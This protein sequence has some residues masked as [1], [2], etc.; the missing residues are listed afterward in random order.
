MGSDGGVFSFGDAAFRGSMATMALNAP[1]TAMAAYGD[2]YIAVA[3]DG[4]VFNFSDRPFAGSLGGGPPIAPV[5]SV[6]TVDR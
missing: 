4:G 6:A 1:V 3:E 5:V 2:G